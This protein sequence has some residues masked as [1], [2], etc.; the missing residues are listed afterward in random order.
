MYEINKLT[1]CVAS[2]NRYDDP[3]SISYKSECVTGHFGMD[4]RELC[5]GHC[6]NNEP[7]DHFSGIC[8]NGCQDGFIGKHCN[9]CKNLTSSR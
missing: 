7:C 1:K 6:I 8:P 4:C 5:S 9:S 3:C 2:S